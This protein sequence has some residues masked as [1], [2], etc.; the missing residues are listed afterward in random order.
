MKEYPLKIEKVLEFEGCSV[1]AYYSK[2]HHNEK[3]FV[4][5]IIKD[6]EYVGNWDSV[7][8]IYIKLS[9]NQIGCMMINYRNTPCKGSFAATVIEV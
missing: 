9:P 8:H 5:T 2:G 7:K 4:N 3:L 6:Y 1:M